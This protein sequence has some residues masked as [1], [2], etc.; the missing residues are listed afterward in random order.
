MVRLR[1]LNRRHNKAAHLQK[2]LRF[3]FGLVQ[4]AVE[5]ALE[6][7][8]DGWGLASVPANLPLAMYQN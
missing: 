8:A 7:T 6:L 3:E 2:E 5:I 1:R 4:A